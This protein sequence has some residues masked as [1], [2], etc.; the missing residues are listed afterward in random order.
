MILLSLFQSFKAA[1]LM[2]LMPLTPLKP[3][4][5]PLKVVKAMLYQIS[6]MVVLSSNGMEEKGT[7]MKSFDKQLTIV[8]IQRTNYRVL[9]FYS[10]QES[11]N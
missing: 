5:Q 9:L 7:K 8:K 1:T 4:R 2:A 6:T 11:V 10:S 3:L